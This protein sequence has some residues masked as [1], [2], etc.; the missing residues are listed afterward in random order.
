M[1]AEVGESRGWRDWAKRKKGLM[2]MDKSVLTAE[3]MVV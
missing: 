1:T 2:E 3:G